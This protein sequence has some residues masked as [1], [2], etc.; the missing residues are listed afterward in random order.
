MLIVFTFEFS[1]GQ[2]HDLYAEQEQIHDDVSNK[3]KYIYF[4][5]FM[6]FQ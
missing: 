5:G 6:N 3:K 4:F 1:P 2:S